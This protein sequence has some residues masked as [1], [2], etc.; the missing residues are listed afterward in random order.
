MSSN[1]RLRFSIFWSYICPS[2]H[3]AITNKIIIKFY[4]QKLSGSMLLV[5]D[6]DLSNTSCEVDSS[7]Y[8]NRSKSYDDLGFRLA[9]TK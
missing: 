4:L 3:F 6:W 5:G 8:Y 9:K 1:L 2:F 7:N